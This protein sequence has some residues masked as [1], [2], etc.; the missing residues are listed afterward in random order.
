MIWN[1]F[2]LSFILFMNMIIL[3]AAAPIF[4]WLTAEVISCSISEELVKEFRL[5]TM[6]S[7]PLIYIILLYCFI[8]ILCIFLGL[9]ILAIIIIIFIYFF[10]LL[11]IWFGLIFFFAC[12]LDIIII[13]S[14]LIYEWSILAC[15]SWTIFIRCSVLSFIITFIRFFLGQLL[16]L[17]LLLWLSLCLNLL[18]L[19]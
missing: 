16:L 7:F 3:I 9:T 4:R 10:F 15:I 2:L 5:L 19:F 6:Y 1:Q 12:D 13:I 11:W 18:L 14:S 17:L 8:I